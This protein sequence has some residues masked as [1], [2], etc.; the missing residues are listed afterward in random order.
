MAC[1]V[2]LIISLISIPLLWDHIKNHPYL[3]GALGTYIFA[4]ILSHCIIPF[5]Y[6]NKNGYSSITTSEEIIKGISGDGKVALVTGGN[7]GLGKETAYIL[8]LAKFKVVLS[9][10][11]L[12]DL[13]QAKDDILARNKTADLEILQCD[14][15]DQE[16]IKKAVET[17]EKMNLPLNILICN[18]AYMGNKHIR[19][20]TK[21]GF[22]STIGINHLGHF[23]L[24]LLLLPLMKKT[25]GER[26]IVMVGSNGQN[27]GE[28]R[29][30]WEDFQMEKT[31]Y[32]GIFPRYA[33]SK[34]ANLM[35]AKELNSKLKQDNI[36][37]T[38]NCLHPGVIRTEL[39]R[40]DG[41][42]FQLISNF[43]ALP[44][45]SLLRKDIYQGISTTIYASVHSELEGEGGLYLSNCD[46][47][48]H[49]PKCADDKEELI[50][51]WKL[52]EEL[53]KVKYS[54]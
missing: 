28:Q 4:Y 6:R 33:H 15:G 45:L 43:I 31:H 47:S 9:G 37:I 8:S 21:D 53:T 11:N 54:K 26:R 7:V 18:A 44:I 39:H 29:I 41:L 5:L 27:H 46:Q 34:L 22:E 32:S 1:L 52:S 42:L 23:T 16:G 20:T 14:L 51:L 25:E 35:F 3:F 12:K 49:Y 36:P 2:S 30:I 40:R 17:F 48:D 24:T 38:V 10:R 19:E 50:K 13:N